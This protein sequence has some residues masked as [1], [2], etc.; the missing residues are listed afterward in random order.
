[1]MSSILDTISSPEDLKNLPFE[2]LEPLCTE[3]RETL[4]QTTAKTGGHLASNLGTVELTVALHR[5][6]DCPADQIVWDVGHQCYTHKLL[7]GRRE[8]FSTL[9]QGGGSPDSPSTTKV[10]T[11]PLSRAI[12]APPSRWRRVWRAP[13]S[14]RGTS[15]T[16]SLS[17]GTGRSP[18]AWRMKGQTTRP[19]LGTI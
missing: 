5:I 3:I 10:N 16:S 11:M 15:T 1:M 6:F 2:E 8:R 9:R 4:I 7:T 17:S 14:C 19:V 12:P 13:K 18:A